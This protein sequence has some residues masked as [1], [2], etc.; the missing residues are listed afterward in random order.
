M[1]I[2]I[3]DKIP[4]IKGAFEEVAEVV[5]LPGS[6]ISAAD[7]RDADALI[8]RTRTHCNQFLLEGSSVK[9]IAT[10]TIGF[11]HIDTQWCDLHNIAWTNAEGCNATSVMQWVASALV[12]LAQKCNFEL[13]NRT[14]GI[15]GV[16]NVGRKILK[17]AEAFDM[18]VVLCDPPVARNISQCGLISLDGVLREADIITLHVPLNMHGIDKTYHLFDYKRLNQIIRGGILLNSSRGEV[19]NNSDLKQILNE[20]H[21]QAAALDVWEN[22]PAIDHELL[23][24]LNLGTPHIAGYSADGKINGTRMSVRAVSKFFG[25][26]LDSWSPIALP[27]PSES[28]LSI[29]AKHKSKQQILTQLILHAYDI[30]AD[31]ARLRDDVIGFEQQRGNYPIRREFSAYS[32]QV[33]NADAKL[34]EAIKLLGFKIL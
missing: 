29:D 31:D 34:V 17:V 2:V 11:D 22:E 3:D 33:K 6:G 9:F 14:L 25:L 15:V 24:K 21:L 23:L 18:R 4:F 7:V 26:G 12:T 28:T 13:K 8:I 30:M 5:Y 27:E 1:K 20:G 10:A 16:G 32:V 19:V